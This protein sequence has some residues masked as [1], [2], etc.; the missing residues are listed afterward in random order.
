[1]PK[2]MDDYFVVMRNDIVD[3]SGVDGFPTFL[4]HNMRGF[5]KSLYQPLADPL[6]L[7]FAVAGIAVFVMGW[8]R[9]PGRHDAT[10]PLNKGFWFAAAVLLTM[11]TTPHALVYDWT[12]LLVP[13]ILLW[14]ARPDWRTQLASLYLIGWIAYPLSV[15]LTKIQRAVEVTVLVQIS[16]LFFAFALYVITTLFLAEPAAPVNETSESVSRVPAA[17]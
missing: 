5:F 12:M 3:L 8:R 14:Q 1:M 11:W 13:A 9:R 10:V 16:V 7:L 15:L 2:A 4:M 6:W 17:T